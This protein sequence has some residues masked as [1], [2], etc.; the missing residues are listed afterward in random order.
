[1]KHT[2]LVP[3]S[4]PSSARSQQDVQKGSNSVAV[5]DGESETAIS[6]VRIS[7][8]IWVQVNGPPIQVLYGHGNYRLLISPFFI[9]CAMFCVLYSAAIRESSRRYYHGKQPLSLAGAKTHRVPHSLLADQIPP[10][11]EGRASAAS[12]RQRIG[13]AILRRETGDGLGKT[14]AGQLAESDVV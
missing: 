11:R 13:H 2:I 10:L 5:D 14:V 1:M 9:T 6:T 4:V 3:S 7:A 8:D 12:R